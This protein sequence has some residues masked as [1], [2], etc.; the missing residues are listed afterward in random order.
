MSVRMAMA[1]TEAE[2]VIGGMLSMCNEQAELDRSEML[3]LKKKV[4]RGFACEER[5]RT[6]VRQRD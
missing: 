3:S 1:M 4:N 6:V 2:W 5:Q